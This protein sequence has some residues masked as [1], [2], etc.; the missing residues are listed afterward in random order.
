MERSSEASIGYGLRLALASMRFREPARAS[1]W[2][3]KLLAVGAGAVGGFFG[4]LTVLAE[5]PLT[6]ALMLRA[7]ADVD[8]VALDAE[9]GV[10]AQ[11]AIDSAGEDVA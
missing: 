1:L 8:A 2:T 5:L 3:H 10:V 11:Q 9:S 7:I 6:T 4:P